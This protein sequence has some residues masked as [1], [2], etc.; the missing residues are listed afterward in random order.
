MGHVLV[1]EFVSRWFKSLPERI[2]ESFMDYR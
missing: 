2:T 1:F